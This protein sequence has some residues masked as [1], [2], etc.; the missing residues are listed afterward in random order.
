M[1]DECEVFILHLF[2]C[3]APLP[4]PYFN[5][6]TQSNFLIPSRN[7]Y[8]H[9]FMFKCV[10]SNKTCCNWIEKVDSCFEKSHLKLMGFGT[11]RIKVILK[12]V[13]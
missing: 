1:L 5:L 2:A 3:S 11:F 8:C 6:Y 7:N 10:Y 9:N 13:M 12:V 4:E